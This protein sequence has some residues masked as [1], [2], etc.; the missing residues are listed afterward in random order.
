MKV[1]VAID[2]FKGALKSQDCN[3]VVKDVLTQKGHQ[4][5]SFPIADGGEG[6]L[7]AL[8][9]LPDWKQVMTP[10]H[11]S[12]FEYI[13]APLMFNGDTAVIET[14]ITAGLQWN[15]ED[16]PPERLTS[17]GVGEQI[18]YADEVLKAK[19]IVVMLG[20]TGVVDGGI[21]IGEALGIRY[22]DKDHH[23]LQSLTGSSLQEISQID[24]T[25]A[26]FPKAKIIMGSDVNA[27]LT[28]DLGA[29]YCFGRQKGIKPADLASYEQMMISYR[30]CC[31]FSESAG[32]GAAGGIGYFLHHFLK[33]EVMS[34]FTYLVSVQDWK[35][36]LKGV[37]LVI[38]GEGKMDEQS[39]LGKLPVKIATY[40]NKPTIAF[41][42][43]LTV[44]IHK[45]QQA[46]LLTAIPIIQYP[47]GLQ[48][49]MQDTADHLQK[50]VEEILPLIEAGLW[51]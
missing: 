1:L 6:S 47:C 18:R 12:R 14:A 26:H 37:D 25:R 45:V 48:T 29:V 19:E 20:G 34:G 5:I 16:W 9:G 4:V 32:D 21:G 40:T 22:Y 3:Q 39:L 30:D 43:Q 13:E 35:K 50:S 7:R 38:T 17:I 2:S 36:H 27:P 41:V 28:G 11:N 23:L 46:G 31:G 33:A 42:G 10:A 24:V 44:S 15:N 8:E 51:R 49:A